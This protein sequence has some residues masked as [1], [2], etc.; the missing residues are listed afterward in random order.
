MTGTSCQ[1]FGSYQY[2][3]GG[4]YD[5]AIVVPDT[6]QSPSAGTVSLTNQTNLTGVN[7]LLYTPGTADFSCFD[8][9]VGQIVAGNVSVT[10]SFSI[11]ASNAA[12]GLVPGGTQPS[13]EVVTLDREVLLND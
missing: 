4:P 8:S 5:F 12:S 11:T 7:F 1:G 9:M 13:G 2:P 10:N 6:G 3:N